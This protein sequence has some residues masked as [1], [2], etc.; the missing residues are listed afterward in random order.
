ME[1]KKTNELTDDALDSVAGGLGENVVTLTCICCHEGQIRT[2]PTG[3]RILS[4]PKCDATLYLY[5]GEI[6][7]C[8]PAPGFARPGHGTDA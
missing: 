3:S 5:D 7:G 1:E 4:C 8:T 2:N 6:V